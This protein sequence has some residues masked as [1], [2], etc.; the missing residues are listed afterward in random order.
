MGGHDLSTLLRGARS[1]T[2]LAVAVVALGA[3]V[4]C[5]I[6]AAGVDDDP[7]LIAVTLF[8]GLGLIVLFAALTGWPWYFQGRWQRRVLA[9]LGM[10]GA[11]VLYG[12]IAGGFV[13]LG[14]GF[15]M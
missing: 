6:L 4:A 7:D 3:C 5:T 8:I 12:L 11:R 15:L 2:A 10:T 14:I 13:G 1:A 9:L